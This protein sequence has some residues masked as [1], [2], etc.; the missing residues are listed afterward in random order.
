MQSQAGQGT[1]AEGIV[2]GV[3]EGFVR[4]IPELLSELI[5]R[6]VGECHNLR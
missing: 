2:V 6:N 1:D 4:E 3:N 5:G